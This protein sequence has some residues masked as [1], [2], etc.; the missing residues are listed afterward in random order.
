MSTLNLT[1]SEIY[2]E[3]AD[4][5]GLDDI[6]TN[7]ENLNK[8]KK[9]TY[10]GFRR[11]LYPTNPVTRKRHLWSFLK[12]HGTISTAKDQWKVALPK[13]FGRLLGFVNF[14]DSRGYPKIV[15]RSS[16]DIIYFRSGTI[17]SSYPEY[18]AIQPVLRDNKQETRWEMWF[19]PTPPQDYRLKF[20][21]LANPEKPENT[22]D[23]L[24]GMPD[25]QEA[26]LEVCLAVAEQQENDI[27]GHHTQLSLGLMNELMTSDTQEKSDS[28]GFWRDGSIP[29]KL[30]DTRSYMVDSNSI[31]VYEE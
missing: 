17:T 10:R 4:F 23:Y 12:K 14:D 27:M 31:S 26:L 20:F 30:V 18:F 29:W 1:F 24:V 19:Y 13:D 2:Q 6:A 9:I 22:T 11:F 15:K 21:Y 8:V 28:Y 7:T 5:L 25:Y 16:E 3:V